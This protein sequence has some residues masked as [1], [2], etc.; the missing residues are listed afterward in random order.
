[1]QCTLS[2]NCSVRLK[3]LHDYLSQMPFQTFSFLVWWRPNFRL[4]IRGVNTTT[5]FTIQRHGGR[6]RSGG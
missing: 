4:K 3:P 2:G 1:L 6:I 5:A